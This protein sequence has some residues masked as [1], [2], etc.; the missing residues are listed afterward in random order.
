MALINH[1]AKDIF[2]EHIIDK[3]LVNRLHSQ[4]N[5]PMYVVENLLLDYTAEELKEKDIEEIRDSIRNKLIKH[6]EGRKLKAELRDGEEMTFLDKITA[7]SVAGKNKYW[8][9][10]L[11]LGVKKAVLPKEIVKK[12]PGLLEN[13]I[14]AE[15]KL[16]YLGEEAGPDSEFKVE[17]LLPCQEASF[18]LAQFKQKVAKLTDFQWLGLL[19]RSIGIE[20]IDLPR[21]QR[22]LLISRLI[23]FVEKN[24]NFVELGARG[25][26]KSYV[27]RQLSGESILVSGGK[28][29]VANLFY[30][31]GTKEIGLV[32]K[33]DVVA[34]DEVAYIDFKDK[35]AIQI[36]KD[37]ME[38][39]AFSR[40]E[41][42]INAEAS[43]V[44]LGNINRNLRILLSNSHLFEPLPDLMR[45]M[46]LIDRF[47]FYLPGWEMK[48]L[49]E[50]DLT[51]NYG[52]QNSYLALALN[53]LREM[54]FSEVI[55]EYYIFDERMDARDKRA[56]K[57]TVSGFLKLLHPHGN[58]DKSNLKSYLDI[59]LEG[60]KR[61]KEQ[62]IRL[63][64]FEYKETTFE[65]QDRQTKE[66]YYPTL[67]ELDNCFKGSLAKPGVVYIGQIIEESD[68]AL[69]KLRV[70]A[71][72]GQ[73][74][75]IFKGEM[76]QEFKNQIR[77][78]FIFLKERNLCDNLGKN[79]NNY[80]FY[81]SIIPILRKIEAD[82]GSAFFVALYS[83]L[84]GKSVT[85]GL[86]VTEKSSIYRDSE[87][88][89]GI[90][91]LKLEKEDGQIKTMLPLKRD[92][93]FVEVPK[94]VISQVSTF[95]TV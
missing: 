30:N 26:G 49:K 60:R 64:S 48:K 50:N 95:I 13:G 85:T 56:V 55:D 47:H 81:I 90:R 89:Y 46:A 37:Y 78:T 39:G 91:A 43:L 92:N 54:D 94:E 76:E 93:V 7:K 3:G 69:L 59:A 83:S 18:D 27:Y 45:D 17:N 74:K 4:L 23:P 68:F 8:A 10:L 87:H 82:I 38:S 51:S 33:W 73:G 80:N 57:K 31:M 58:F 29:T 70:V 2:P 72:P 28:T 1:K 86:L 9:Q 35:T 15:V 61:V 53:E 77:K 34:F 65:Y 21:R 44:F 63:G 88:T 19:L 32:G 25:T 79:V 75:L 66:Q 84:S 36:L 11:H 14:W 12:H 5:L 24:Y 42:E 16:S 71:E 67:P 62:L 41:E 6:K 40:G 22:L 20:S 52:L